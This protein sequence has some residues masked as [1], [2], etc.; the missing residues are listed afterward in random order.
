MAD[1][2]FTVVAVEV[3]NLTRFHWREM[4]RYQLTTATVDRLTITD[5]VLSGPALMVVLHKTE[6]L[7]VPASVWLSQRKG[8]SD[9]VSQAP[10]CFRRTLRQPNRI[11]SYFHVADE[12]ADIVRELGILLEPESRLRVFRAMAEGQS[13][14]NDH[15]RLS[16]AL[17][18]S[19]ASARTLDSAS[20]LDAVAAALQ[21]GPR[22]E[23]TKTAA[24]AALADIARMRSGERISWRQ[25]TAALA[26]ARVDVDRWTL[27]RIG[28]AFIVYDQPGASKILNSVDPGLWRNKDTVEAGYNL[29][30]SRPAVSGAV[31]SSSPK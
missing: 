24:T 13:Q 20:A 22:D 26:E 4:W 10:D 6:K 31:V 1:S 29:E 25:F 8:I 19:D 11:F 27:A 18:G 28:A 12:P 3:P 7:D 14:P 30:Y 17:E 23:L 15:A 9:P 5:L 21:S 2:G 16:R